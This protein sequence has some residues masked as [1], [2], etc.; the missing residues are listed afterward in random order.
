VKTKTNPTNNATSVTVTRELRREDDKAMEDDGQGPQ[1][2]FIKPVEPTVN[3]RAD[4]LRSS[5][6]SRG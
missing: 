3:P 2:K 6:G 5:R 4:G 1:K